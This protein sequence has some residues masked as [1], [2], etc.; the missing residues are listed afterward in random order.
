MATKKNE[1]EKHAQN[2]SMAFKEV[3]R[4]CHHFLV[5]FCPSATIR[6][7]GHL[8]MGEAD[9]DELHQLSCPSKG[10][11]SSTHDLILSH[12]PHLPCL[13]NQHPRVFFLL[14]FQAVTIS[15]GFYCS[16]FLL[17]LFFTRWA[18]D[19]TKT[20]KSTWPNFLGAKEALQEIVPHQ[21]CPHLPW[22]SCS[23]SRRLL[24][25]LDYFVGLQ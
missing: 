25:V 9:V 22:Q 17:L 18:A 19:R 7:L 4:E 23:A 6:D 10:Q 21:H 3:L 13:H 8:P 16:F 20:S 12:L 5:R 14:A 2:T 11:G 24:N 15:H 1:K